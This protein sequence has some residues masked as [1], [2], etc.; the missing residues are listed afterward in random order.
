MSDRFAWQVALIAGLQVAC[1]AAVVPAVEVAAVAVAAVLPDVTVVVV[2]FA[3]VVVGVVVPV[4]ST[5]FDDTA[6]LP[7][8]E[9]YFQVVGQGWYS[10]VECLHS[11]VSAWFLYL[12]VADSHTQVE[13]KV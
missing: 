8:S 2:V 6:V 12:Q 13:A 5:C 3:A 7:A 10:V 9:W 4:A 1:F 11:M